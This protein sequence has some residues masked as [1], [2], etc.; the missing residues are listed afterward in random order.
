MD[1]KNQKKSIVA[2]SN[3]E[4]LL[5]VPK[6]KGNLVW[7]EQEVATDLCIQLLSKEQ[8]PTVIKMK[9]TKNTPCGPGTRN[10]DLA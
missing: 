1:Q 7:I 2:R 5:D 8:H 6:K 10:R 9:E 4:K 3:V